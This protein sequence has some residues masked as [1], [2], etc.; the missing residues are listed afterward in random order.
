MLSPFPFFLPLSSSFFSLLTF[1]PSSFLHLRSFPLR[2]HL[3]LLLFH[4][5]LLIPLFLLLSLFLHSFPF[6]FPF[7]VLPHP[8]FLSPPPLPLSFSPF[9]I[10]HSPISLL[11]LPSPSLPSFLLQPTCFAGAI[12]ISQCHHSRYHVYSLLFKCRDTTCFCY[13]YLYF[14]SVISQ[15]RDLLCPCSLLLTSLLSLYKF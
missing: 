8:L 2:G 15:R 12:H 11:H 5:I 10:S 6:Y 14:I 3:L 7:S 13:R 1:F 9:F 4:L